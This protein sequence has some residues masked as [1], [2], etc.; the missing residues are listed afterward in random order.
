MRGVLDTIE[1]AAARSTLVVVMAAP[2]AYDFNPMDVYNKS[3][4]EKTEFDIT[5]V[6]SK[7]DIPATA[8]NLLLEQ[9]AKQYSNVL[10]IDRDSLF[11]VDGIPSEITQEKIPYSFDGLHISTYGSLSA[12]AAFLQSQKYKDLITMLQVSE[13]KRLSQNSQAE[14]ATAQQ[15]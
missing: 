15:L 7:R 4:L 2:K 13:P 8:A 12:A 10:Y 5:K 6:P 9:T 14:T 3:L 11:N 1:Y